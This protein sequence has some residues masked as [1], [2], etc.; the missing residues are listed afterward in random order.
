MQGGT[1][2]GDWANRNPHGQGRMIYTD[3]SVYM[4]GWKDFKFHGKGK[5]MQEGGVVFDGEWRD[6]RMHGV[7]RLETPPASTRGATVGVANE[8]SL[9]HTDHNGG[10]LTKS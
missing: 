2:E 9:K 3:G 6:G 7:G 8:R 1:Y 4:G 5:L 10:D